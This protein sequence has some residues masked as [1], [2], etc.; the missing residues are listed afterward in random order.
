MS[1]LRS[2][3]VMCDDCK[4]VWTNL[5]WSCRECP[6]DRKCCRNGGHVGEEA[7]G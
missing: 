7:R 4:T 3:K 5:T 2:G 6:G 1:L